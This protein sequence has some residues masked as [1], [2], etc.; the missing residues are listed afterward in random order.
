M[1]LQLTLILACTC[2]V[3]PAIAQTPAPPDAT[4]YLVSPQDGDTVSSPVTVRFG[5]SG[6]GVAPAG[7]A[8]AGTGHHHLLIDTPP[9]PRQ[10]TIPSDSQYRHFGN[11]QTEAVIP[12]APGTHTL[13]L[14][15][16]D[17]RHRPHDPPLLSE[18]IRITV[19]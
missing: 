10:R 5:L 17:A 16:G 7:V 8:Q 14:L 12:L 13:Q 1:P 3:V 6:M 15:F 2:I 18:Q 19:R 4:V 9:P 11:G